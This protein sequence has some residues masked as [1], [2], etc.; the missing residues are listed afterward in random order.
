VI[1]LVEGPAVRR[2]VR[3]LRRRIVVKA[4]R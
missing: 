4:E 2:M 1:A 3:F